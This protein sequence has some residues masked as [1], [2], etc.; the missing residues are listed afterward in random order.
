MIIQISKDLFINTDQV[1]YIKGFTDMEDKKEKTFISFINK[2]FVYAPM[3]FVEFIK[4]L[5]E[6]YV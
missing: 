6:N 1:N 2:D 4:V 5:K 3:S